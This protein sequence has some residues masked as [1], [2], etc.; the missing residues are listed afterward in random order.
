MIDTTVPSDNPVFFWKNLFEEVQKII[1]IIDN[2]IKNQNLQYDINKAAGEEIL[3]LQQHR[4]IQETKFTYSPLG[5][6]LKK[7]TK[8]IEKYAEKQV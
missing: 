8:T 2:K 6:A 7:Q 1:M 5:K 4:I 3:P